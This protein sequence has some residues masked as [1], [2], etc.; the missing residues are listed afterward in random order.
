MTSKT[1]PP[2]R[3]RWFRLGEDGAA[4]IEMAFAAPVFLLLLLGIFEL[5]FMVFVQ[6]VLDGC[7]RDAARLIRTGQVASSTSPQATFQT[8]LCNEMAVIVGCSKLIFNVQ[9]FG[10]FST[11][12]LAPPKDKNGNPVPTFNGGNPGS[13]MLVE[14]IYNRPF[15]TQMIG[16]YLGGSSRSAFLTSTV[17]FR[18][19][20]FPT[21][22]S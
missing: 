15:I 10:T 13:D 2:R 6:S 3:R 16:Q 22:S 14:V 5:G 1:A 11:Y 18:N 20:P 4:A 17:I 21:G 9:P 8:L 19:E 7:A 12:T